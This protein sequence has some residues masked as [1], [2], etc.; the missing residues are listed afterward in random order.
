M[1]LLYTACKPSSLTRAS[2]QNGF[3][4]PIQFCFNPLSPFVTDV[5]SYMGPLVY[6]TNHLHRASFHK[7]FSIIQLLF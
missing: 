7:R 1:G 4:C 6:G 2:I 5:Y 3:N